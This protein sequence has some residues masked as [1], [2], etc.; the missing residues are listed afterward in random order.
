V[1]QVTARSPAAQAGLQADDVILRFDGAPI[2]NDE[3][4]ISLVK[5]S[6][7]RQVELQVFRKGQLLTVQALIGRMDELGETVQKAVEPKSR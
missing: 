1:K 5:P 3:H 6:V 4:L 7:G 2:E